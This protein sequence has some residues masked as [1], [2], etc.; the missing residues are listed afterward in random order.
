[1]MNKKRGRYLCPFCRVSKMTEFFR[2][3]VYVKRKKSHSLLLLL[4]KHLLILELVA[5]F[6]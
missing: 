6:V 1:M 2:L 4:N 5:I 3:Y